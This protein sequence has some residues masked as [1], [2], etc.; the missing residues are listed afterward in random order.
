MNTLSTFFFENFQKFSTKKN[1]K[2]AIYFL[3]GPR[4]AVFFV[5]IA[6]IVVDFK[7]LVLEAPKELC[8]KIAHGGGSDIIIFIF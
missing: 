4:G 1:L 3:K 7:Q 8:D 5:L 6:K 2:I